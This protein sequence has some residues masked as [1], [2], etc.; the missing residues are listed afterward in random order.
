MNISQKT[1]GF[2]WGRLSFFVQNDG[3]GGGGVQVSQKKIKL[4][5]QYT[6]GVMY[7]KQLI[8]QTV[9]FRGR[10][11]PGKQNKYEKSGGFSKWQAYH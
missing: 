6:Y 4:F 5:M 9:K 2:C 8:Y 1:G 7:L 3:W 11:M 10:V